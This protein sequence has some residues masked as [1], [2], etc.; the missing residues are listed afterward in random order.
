MG[1]HWVGYEKP[2]Y[3][4]YQYI[5]GRGEYPNFHH[6]MGFNSCIRS[7]QMFSPVSQST[8]WVLFHAVRHLLKKQRQS[9][10][11]LKSFIYAGKNRFTGPPGDLVIWNGARHTPMTAQLIIIPFISVFGSGRIMTLS[12]EFVQQK[13]LNVYLKIFESCTFTAGS[14]V[15]RLSLNSDI[16]NVQGFLPNVLTT[17]LSN[18]SALPWLLIPLK[19]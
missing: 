14:H 13:W 6:W 16:K 2:N 11:S 7:C 9:M 4:G 10:S 19:L 8:W 17:G 12:L 5:L 1:G 18:V 3:M 15:Q